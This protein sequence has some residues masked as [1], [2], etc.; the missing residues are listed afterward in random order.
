MINDNIR[1]VSVLESILF[2]YSDPLSLKDLL[3]VFEKKGEKLRVLDIKQALDLLEKKYQEPL[4][5]LKLI[6]VEDKYQIST[7]SENYEYVSILLNPVKKKSLTQASLETLS[8]IAYKQPATKIEVE[9][10]RGVKSDKAIST[11]LEAGLI[12]EAGRLDKIGRPIIYK[13]T[14]K[15]LLHFGLGSVRDLPAITEE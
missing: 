11:L 14:D 7:R 1:V 12:E 15:F 10:I 2:A 8:I 13:T 6:K 9:N 3:A 4:S 5:G